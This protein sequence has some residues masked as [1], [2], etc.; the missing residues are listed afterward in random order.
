M[1][2]T[3]TPPPFQPDASLWRVCVT[4]RP[5]FILDGDYLGIISEDHA[6]RIA[7]D[8]TGEADLSRISAT[9]I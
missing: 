2:N 3:E 7:A 1:L 5:A 6:T 9:R 4:G 8:V